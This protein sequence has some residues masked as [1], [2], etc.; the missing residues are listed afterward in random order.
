MVNYTDLYSLHEAFLIPCRSCE[1]TGF[2]DGVILRFQNFC[3]KIYDDEYENAYIIYGY[4][5]NE[6]APKFI[7]RVKWNDF[8]K[9]A[10]M[11]TKDRPLDCYKFGNIC[12]CV[13]NNE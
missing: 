10:A 6:A 11:F 8:K 9:F 3:L 12:Q 2:R 1:T 7:Y 5:Y 4:H 13:C